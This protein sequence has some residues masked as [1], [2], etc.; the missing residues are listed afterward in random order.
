MFG[1]IVL[2]LILILQYAFG[3]QILDIILPIKP[4][5]LIFLTVYLLQYLAGVLISALAI[6]MER[7]GS[8]TAVRYLPAI[9][10]YY[11]IYNP[12]LSLAKVDAMMRF[13]RGG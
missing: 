7:G 2:P 8:P 3:F 1:I 5:V 13:F 11:A 10:I 6:A 9:F 4:M 12:L